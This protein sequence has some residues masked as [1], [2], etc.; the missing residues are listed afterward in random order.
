MNSESIFSLSASQI[1][2]AYRSRSLSPVELMHAVIDR[3]E[4]VEPSINAFADQYFEE[5]LEKARKAENKFKNP[6]SRPRR[7]EGIPLTV[8]DDTPVK[9][10]RTTGGSLYMRDHLDTQTNPSVE[11]LI[12]AGS[13]VHARSTCPEFCWT[14][15]TSTR[16][17]GVTRN[18]WN[19]DLSPGGSSGGSAASVAA[20]STVLAT[21]TDSAGSIRQPAALCGVVGYKAPYGRNPQSPP[22]AFDVYHHTGP[23]TRSVSDCIL[24]QNIMAGPHPRDHN[25]IRPKLRIP[26]NPKPIKGMKI[27]WSMDL[28]YY[29]VTEDVRTR[30]LDTLKLLESAGAEIVEIEMGWAVPAL[31]ACGYYGSHLY[32]DDFVQ[33]VNDYP[34]QVCDYTQYFAERNQKITQQQ[35]HQ[36]HSVAGQVWHDHFGPMLD[37][38]D[39][40]ICPT[41]TANNLPAD[42]RPWDTVEVN[43][44]QVTDYDTVMT[45]LFNMYSRCPVLS[46]PSGFDS[47]G[48]PTSIQI[49][50]KP[51]DDVSVFRIGLGLEELAQE[52][53][54]PMLS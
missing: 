15:V 39:A 35:V 34:D 49:V 21:G 20:G 22:V 52:K 24:M 46:V 25:A 41:V 18:P 14:W 26:E 32:S 17:H 23:I 12:R 29:D 13:I 10:K 48:M 2:D 19:L 31:D 38:Y 16:I 11:R 47:N 33:V 51:Y 50:G 42:M 9:G 3:A 40:F 7:L 43:G 5:A 27:A 6:K 54:W 30:T 28:G 1:L 44:K 53:H 4:L 37:R 45:H 8:K 36:A